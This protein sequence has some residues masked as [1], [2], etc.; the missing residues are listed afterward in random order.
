M[1]ARTRSIIQRTGWGVVGVSVVYVLWVYLHRT[2]GD[3]EAERR[4]ERIRR[5]RQLPKPLADAA[6]GVQILQFYASTPEIARGERALVCYGVL[7]AVSVRI[8]PKVEE[9][10]PALSRC[11]EVAPKASTR[12]TLYAEGSDG[13]RASASFTLRVREPQ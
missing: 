1:T 2:I 9:L 10:K 7:N 6:P 11:F 13:V 8:E 5:A 3:W 12:Y 4:A